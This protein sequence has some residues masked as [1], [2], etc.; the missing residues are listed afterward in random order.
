MTLDEA[1]YFHF[2]D[3]VGDT[4]RWKGEN[5]ATS[6]VNQAILDFPGVVEGATYGVEIPAADG[7]A[8]MAAIVVDDRFDLAQ[9]HEHL[10][11]R[12]PAYACPVMVR[13]CAALDSTETF[14]QK[15]QDLMREGFDPG[16]VGDPLFYRDPASGSYRSL[17][18][19]SHA[20]ILD[21]SIRL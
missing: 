2:V 3:R 11:R 21:G 20:G 13:I 8:G 1:G 10:A 15:K 9:L 6:E 14:K 19:A 17:D 12:L 7:R 18:A 4:F 5:V 16:L